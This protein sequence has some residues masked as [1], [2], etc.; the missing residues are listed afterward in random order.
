MNI[1]KILNLL[2]LAG[3]IPLD[4]QRHIFRIDPFPIILHAN[5]LTSST[6]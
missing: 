5:E 6:R 2:E 4:G 1:I 3:G